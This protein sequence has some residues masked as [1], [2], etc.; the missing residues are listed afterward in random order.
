MENLDENLI[1]KLIVLPCQDRLPLRFLYDVIFLGYWQKLHR[2]KIDASRQKNS[3][4]F[5]K[6][7]Q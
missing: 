2:G 5:L 6:I 7:H 4:V 3:I 1:H